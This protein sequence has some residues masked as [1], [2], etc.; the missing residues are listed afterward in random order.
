MPTLRILSYTLITLLLFGSGCRE[1]D[2]KVIN[3]LD[4]RL[5]MQVDR[6]EGELL[7]V[8]LHVEKSLNDV[9]R[10]AL[11]AHGVVFESEAGALYVCRLPLKA[12]LP[13]A[14]EPFV[15][16][17]EAPKVLKPQ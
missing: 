14:R 8:F 2:T 11:E 12:I 4:P 5:K 3:K 16:R 1:E 10:Q 7:S 15:I 13:V 17:L 6:L 9:Q